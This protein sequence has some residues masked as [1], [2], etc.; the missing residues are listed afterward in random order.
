MSNPRRDRRRGGSV[1]ETALFLPWYVFLFIG[2][3]DW[4]FYS[5]AL[6]STQNAARVAAL[7]TSYSKTQSYDQPSACRLALEE[8][9][10]SGNVGAGVTTCDAFPV[11][12]TAVTAGPGTSVASAD[13]KLA[14]QVTVKYR[15]A[16][17]IPIPG[18]LTNQATVS[19][20][21]QMRLRNLW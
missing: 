20:V 1:I 10:V 16:R 21:I 2:A 15:T 18:V 4:G 6:I 12:V 19:Q 9:R 8:L 14:T 11:I 3:V 17:L 7:Y 13:G 5:H